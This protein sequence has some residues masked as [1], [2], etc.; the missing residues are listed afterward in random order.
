MWKRN[1]LSMASKKTAMIESLF[2]ERYDATTGTLSDDVVTLSQVTDAIRKAAIST[3][4]GIG[5]TS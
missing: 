3:S 4:D 1:D 5:P 2:F